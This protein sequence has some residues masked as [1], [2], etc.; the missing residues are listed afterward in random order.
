MGEEILIN[1]I[2]ALQIDYWNLWKLAKKIHLLHELY[3]TLF[4]F[5]M[6]GICGVIIAMVDFKLHWIIITA[7]LT[8]SA[9]LAFKG[10]RDDKKELE[11]LAPNLERWRLDK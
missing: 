2:Y 11:R 7:L 6:L 1:K 10:I 8:F 9:I 5:I 3:A 4:Y